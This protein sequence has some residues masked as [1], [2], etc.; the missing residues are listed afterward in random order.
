MPSDDRSIG[1][2]HAQQVIAQEIAKKL[3]EMGSENQQE[4]IG[5]E[6]LSLGDFVSDEAVENVLL[7]ALKSLRA[8]KPTDRSEKARRYAVTITEMEKVC[9]YFK[10]YVID[11]P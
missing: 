7:T 8:T 4:I 3:D 2:I 11:N 10:V 5:I 1:E 6:K 9:A